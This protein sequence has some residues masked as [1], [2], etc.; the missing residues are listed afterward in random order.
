MAALISPRPSDRTAPASPVSPVSPVSLGGTARA[1]LAGLAGAGAGAAAQFATVV[2]VTR[3]TDR[4]T[5]GAFF[6]AT[7]LCLTVAGIL[8]LDAGNGLIRLIARSRPL[9]YGPAR[10]YVRAAFVPVAALSLT[11]ATAAALRPAD[12]AS[13]VLAFA[14]PAVVCAEVAV[15]ATRGFGAMRPTVL[16]TG[17]FLPAAQLAGVAL[18]LWTARTGA[19]G[20]APGAWIGM[21]DPTALSG[22]AG[23]AGM[24]PAVPAIVD[25][26]S[27]SAIAP[28]TAP[29]IA[30][31]AVDAA[32]L[33]ALAVAWVWP[34]A[35]VLAP[36]ALWLRRRLPR[37]PR[38]PGAALDLWRDTWPRSAAAALQSVFQRLDVLVVAALAGPAEAA[39]YTAATRFKVVG[40]LAGQGLA[41]AVQPR[42]VRALSEGDLP[43]ARALYQSATMW[44][45]APTW[46][47]WLG[48]AVLAPWLLGVFGDGYASGVPV[49]LVLAGT[50][51]AATACGMADVALSAAGHTRA[52]LVNL[53]AAV[54]TTVALDALLVPSE[55]VLGAALG[56]SGGTLVKNLL[57]LWR[58]N[59]L[60]GLRP[61]GAH[62][63]AALTPWRSPWRSPRRSPRLRAG[64]GR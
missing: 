35:A 25:A 4:Q 2:L 26:G 33:T 53:V 57:P 62:S 15:A 14:L 43:R 39:V 20:P 22:G 61:F 49:A 18:V 32:T 47:I 12:P 46:P 44:L 24:P 51:M 23:G 50:M 27:P 64:G 52:G 34:Y 59:R 10:G 30:P 8:R 9:G 17:L 54:A 60:Y 42:L 36:A 11:A 13:R 1:G 5:A 6:T 16:L 29:G 45:V 31:A 41:H 55:G 56:W 7:A 40:Q 48:Y 28:D 21:T 19:G 63:V 3:E 38:T 58:I 37:G